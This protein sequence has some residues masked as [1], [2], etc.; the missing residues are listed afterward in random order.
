MKDGRIAGLQD[1]GIAGLQD[2]GIAGLQKGRM[3]GRRASGLDTA[4]DIAILAGA[5]LAAF[6]P[7]L[8]NGFVNWDDPA[9]LL[10]NSHLEGPG[11]SAWAFSTTLIGHYQPLAWLAWSAAKAAFGLTPAPFHAMSLILHLANGI[12]VYALTVRLTGRLQHASRPPIQQ[13]RVAGLIA[14]LLFLLHPTSVETVAWASA[15]P[16]VLSTFALLLSLLAYVRRRTGLSIGCYAV[17]L[18]ARATAVG[19]PLILLALDFSLL[20]RDAGNAG[21][22]DGRI[23]GWQK[24]RIL[25][26]L[27]FAALA[28]LGAAA[29]WFS[30]DVASLQEIGLGPRLT[31]VV[32]APFVYAWRIIWPVRLSPLHPLPISPQAEPFLLAAG[33]SAAVATTIVLWRWRTYSP[34]RAAGWVA[35]L[36][37]LVLLAPIAGF[38]PTGLQ[39]TADRY[40][41]V[42]TVVMAIAFGSA[43]VRQL[44]FPITIRTAAAGAAAAAAL[45]VLAMLTWR[46]AEYWHDSITLWTRAVELD[47]RNDVATYNLAAALG[48]AGRDQEAITWYER[49]LELVPDHALARQNA[50][51]LR[52]AA[53]ERDADRLAAAGR[54][55]PAIDDYGRA[56]ALDPKRSHA[57]AA[58]G[59]LLLKRGQL[60]QATVDLRRAMDD[61]VKDV[62]VPNA[63]AFA[64]VQRGDAAQAVAVLTR[65]MS[66]HPDNVNLEHNLARLLATAPDPRV[67]DARRALQLAQEVCDRTGNR[68]P[69]ALDT[70]AAAYA[71]GG[72]V[73]EAREVARQA[74]DQ[75]RRLGDTETAAE[76]IAHARSYQR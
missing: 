67:R 41:Y 31:M 64:L 7:V 72:R 22:R 59:I 10:N 36:A 69:R 30:R 29:E 37:W 61:G 45:A 68:D 51:Y 52:A 53:A 58:R 21:W 55:D 5:T 56:L 4:A 28:V 26:N 76:I 74:A 62:E 48:E 11:V 19:Y 25:R 6:W 63:L 18:L 23:A 16:Y 42:P 3:P 20:N 50:S 15:F 75:A 8:R 32:T 65:A 33:L 70:L 13:L 60:D 2:G 66:E 46:Q 54:V 73:D 14:G 40:L 1:R 35:W 12:M 39:A 34:A 27:P 44:R 43:G 24:G 17:S 49:T 71:A 47:A 38:T 57:R 9:V